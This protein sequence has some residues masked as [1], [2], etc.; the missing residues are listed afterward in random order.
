MKKLLSLVIVLLSLFLALPAAAAPPD[1]PKK[2]AFY[3]EMT[4]LMEK[5]VVSGYSDGTVRPDVEVTR[6]QAAVMIGRLK[7]FDGTKGPTPF[8]DVSSAHYASGYIAEAAEAGYLKGY[9]DGTFRPNAPIIRGDMALIV[10]RVFDLSF[11]FNSSFKDVG[12]NAVYSEAISKILAANITV[13]YPDNTFR[14]RQAVTRG[15]FSAFLARALEPKFKNDAVIPDSYLKDK[16]KT[17]TYQMSDG[18]TAVHRYQNV[19]NRDGLVYGFMWTAQVDGDSYEYLELE[20]YSIFAYG[21]PYSEYDIALAYP[22]RVGR[23]FDTGLE[24]EIIKNT[25]TGVNKTVTTKY[26]TFTNATEVMTQS[27]LKYYMVEGYATV[28]SVNAQG[29]VEMELVNVR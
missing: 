27:G 15:Q 17:Y 12:P 9:G 16:T 28:K 3:D 19:P 5:G 10:E 18:T 22:V 11:T 29:R 25:I 21:Y 1:L 20:N 24:D 26:K 23:T 4:Y 14:P 2:H 8:K 13:G 7:G 6:A